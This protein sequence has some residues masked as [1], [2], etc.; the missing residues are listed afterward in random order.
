MLEAALN[1]VSI[2]YEGANKYKVRVAHKSIV[3]ARH[4]W[5][6]PTLSRTRLTQVR[7]PAGRPMYFVVE[8]SGCCSR[9]RGAP[10]LGLSDSLAYPT[11]TGEG[12]GR[13][14]DVL[15]RRGLGL[16]FAS[17]L[18]SQSLDDAASDGHDRGARH[19]DEA[20]VDVEL[21]LLRVR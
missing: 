14:P 5:V 3:A 2:G 18:Q 6:S 19:D 9:H 16:L 17:M 10:L 11:R 20:A 12:S 21:L 15:C 13:P 8:D 7:D 4:C 1:T